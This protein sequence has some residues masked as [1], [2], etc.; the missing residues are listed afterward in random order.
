[1]SRVNVSQYIVVLY[2]PKKK[3][4]QKRFPPMGLFSRHGVTNS[5]FQGYFLF[6]GSVEQRHS[7][8][9]P[10]QRLLFFSYASKK[11]CFYMDNNYT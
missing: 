11:N 2:E 4:Q 3:L 9:A 6:S 1:M 7:T 5:F 10:N 8:D